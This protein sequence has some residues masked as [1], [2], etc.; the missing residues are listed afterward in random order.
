MAVAVR[1]VE[2]DRKGRVASQ[3]LR[4]QHRQCYACMRLKH[5]VTGKPHGHPWPKLRGYSHGLCSIC[6]EREFGKIL[7]RPHNG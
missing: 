5:N 3:R 4:I 7:A 6:L 2:L 1:E